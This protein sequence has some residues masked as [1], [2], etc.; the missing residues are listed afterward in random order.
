MPDGTRRKR[1]GAPTNLDVAEINGGSSTGLDF[2]RVSPRITNNV[3]SSSH[4]SRT[5]PSLLTPSLSIISEKFA[6]MATSK[7]VHEK[8]KRGNNMF[9]QGDNRRGRGSRGGK[10]SSSS[11]G[12]K[13]GR[14]RN[15]K[16]RNSDRGK[17][18]RNSQRQHGGGRRRTSSSGGGGGYDGQMRTDSPP[19]QP[20][21][22]SA[23]FH[24]GGSWSLDGGRSPPTSV[25]G[26]SL[27][28]LP[29]LP[30]APRRGWE[31]G[32]LTV[33]QYNVLADGFYACVG[34]YAAS[35]YGGFNTYSTPQQRCWASRFPRLV[36]EFD[37]TAP[38]LLCLQ[39]VQY[40]HY[41]S[42]F[43]PAMHARGYQCFL[44][45]RHDDRRGVSERD[46]YVAT[47]VRITAAKVLEQPVI[48]RFHE[49]AKQLWSSPEGR[50]VLF[51]D[52]AT[53]VFEENATRERFEGFLQR[54]A[55]ADNEAIVAVCGSTADPDQQF[56]VVN[57]HLYWNPAYADVKSLQVALLCHALRANLERWGLF[58]NGDHC[59]VVMCTDLNS[60]PRDSV[61]HGGAEGAYVLMTTGHLGADHADHPAT[62]TPAIEGVEG[63]IPRSS[64]A[65]SMQSLSTSGIQWK[66][67]YGLDLKNRDESSD[68]SK[69]PL[70]TTK[71]A[72]FSGEFLCTNTLRVRFEY[73]SSWFIFVSLLTCVGLCVAG[74]IDYIFVGGGFSVIDR[75]ALPY[76]PDTDAA[77]AFQPMPNS[78]FP[79]DHLSLAARLKLQLVD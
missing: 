61:V 23:G 63:S 68:G 3:Y 42:F 64:S 57:A 49:V 74:C 62:D 67:V 15:N 19:F 13:G 5:H 70:I 27:A 58:S 39:E 14:G 16:G 2:R 9:K 60:Q 24:P 34:E 79:S 78:M 26:C 43:Y 11:R 41:M 54:L 22:S 31:A 35:S 76:Q 25:P 44:S 59:P 69:E 37:A 73:T 45:R 1:R 28:T 47:F 75:C 29:I 18:G 8:Q 12:G 17:N 48:V 21:S 7:S 6:G 20:Q 4:P 65:P 72:S 71:T 56:V 38:D 46:L 77:K 66:S 50:K 52:A 40:E 32:L 51:G 36:A 30:P 55:D 10:N 33:M 53:Q